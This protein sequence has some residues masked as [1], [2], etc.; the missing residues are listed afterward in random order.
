MKI[1]KMKMLFSFDD[2]V[3]TILFTMWVC[4]M[5]PIHVQRACRIVIPLILLCVFGD[6]VY[7]LK[8]A[9][10]MCGSEDNDCVLREVLRFRLLFNQS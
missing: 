6:I 2:V 4:S 5:T 9:R 8:H 3:I 10:I 1:L 7:A